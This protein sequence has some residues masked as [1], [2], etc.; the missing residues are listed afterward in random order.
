MTDDTTTSRRDFVKGVAT[1]AIGGALAGMGLYS[2]TDSAYDRLAKVTHQQQDF[3]AVRSVK[4]TAISETSW[5]NN[6][7]LMQNIRAA[8]G[9]LVD[10]YTIGWGPF[11]N[12][13]GVGK[14]SYEEGIASIKKMLPN[15]L[16]A[17]WAIQTKQSLHPRQSGWLRHPA[18][19]RGLGR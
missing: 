2:Y 4:V 7:H 14:G 19:G 9:L 13:K 11:G 17:A 18:R 10:Q 6:A 3:G 16:E 8:G 5:F 12:G 1:G 15:D